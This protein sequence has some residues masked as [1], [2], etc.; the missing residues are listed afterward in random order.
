ML[1]CGCRLVCRS[2]RSPQLTFDGVR[3]ML[4]SDCRRQYYWPVAAA[5]AIGHSLPCTSAAKSSI[6][7]FSNTWPG[8]V[9]A[10]PNG[11]VDRRSLAAPHYLQRRVPRSGWCD[12]ALFPGL[13]GGRLSLGVALPGSIRR[14]AASD[15][16]GPAGAPAGLLADKVRLTSRGH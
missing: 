9:K 4:D 13:L 11:R 1:E 3:L 15:I 16:Q 2:W 10:A 8:A 5:Q 12:R 7:L 6:S 14:P